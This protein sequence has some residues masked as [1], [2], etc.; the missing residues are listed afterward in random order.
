[1]ADLLGSGELRR[2]DQIPFVLSVF[3]IHHHHHFA[4]AD[5]RQAIGDGVE[6][7]CALVQG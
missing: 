4:I 2:A 6:L 7:E 3:V 5:R 1:V